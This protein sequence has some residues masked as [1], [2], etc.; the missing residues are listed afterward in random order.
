MNWIKRNTPMNS[1]RNILAAVVL[2]TGL[3][4]AA[5]AAETVKPLQGVSFHAPAMDAVAY[6]LSESRSCKVV[7]TMA[8]NDQLTRFEAAISAG[9][10]SSYKLTEGKSLEVACRADA[11]SMTINMVATVA[12]K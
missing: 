11:Q 8:A 7:L 5:H 4:V 12:A 10:S 3:S 6:F 2:S 9:E 1:V